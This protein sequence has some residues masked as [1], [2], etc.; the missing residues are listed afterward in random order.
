MEHHERGRFNAPHIIV[1]V[2]IVLTLDARLG[3]DLNRKF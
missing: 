1:R 2:V 3:F